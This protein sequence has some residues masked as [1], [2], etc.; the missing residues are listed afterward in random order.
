MQPIVQISLDLTDI[1]EA[2]ETAR[3]ALE[4]GVDWLEAGTP[5]ILAEGLHGVRSAKNFRTRLSSLI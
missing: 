4:A 2:I 5:L 1:N 3:I